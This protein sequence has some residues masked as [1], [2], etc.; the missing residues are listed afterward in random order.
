MHKYDFFQLNLDA[1][2]LGAAI[3]QIA[4]ANA[5]IVVK[6]RVA[7]PYI[8]KIAIGQTSILEI[9]AY[10]YPDYGVLEA[11]VSAIAPDAIAGE[12]NSAPYYEVTV[13][14]QKTYLVKRDR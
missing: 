9:S 12:N 10:P 1:F 2:T 7:S 4:P 11:K 13:M 8:G 14:A 3:A 6:A 5:A